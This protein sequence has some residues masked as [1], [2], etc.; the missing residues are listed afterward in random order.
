MNKRKLYR[1]ITKLHST[2]SSRA[3]QS[4]SLHTFLRG[5]SFQETQ[6]LC[7]EHQTRG[8]YYLITKLRERVSNAIHNLIVFWVFKN[9]P[10]LC[11]NDAVLIFQHNIYDCSQYFK[12]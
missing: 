6:E 5:N 1:E 3:E 9:F 7:I 10:K 11:F 8:R 2:V 4:S 12:W